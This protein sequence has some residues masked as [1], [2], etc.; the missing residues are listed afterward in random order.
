MATTRAQ[1]SV[2]PGER[3]REPRLPIDAEAVIRGRGRSARGTVVDASASGVLIELSEALPFLDHHVGIEMTMA[4]GSTVHAE[5]EIVRRALSPAGRVLVAIRLLEDAA[6]RELIRSA[7]L[8]PLRDYGR[9]QRPSR[10]KPRAP[11]PRDEVLEELRALGSRVLELALAEPDASAPPAMRRWVL[12]L[13]SE[14]GGTASPPATN[15]LLLREI[16][17]LHAR[18]TED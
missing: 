8:K 10:A 16:A 1:G 15:R 12:S 7:G 18:A 17:H 14:L 5:G 13:A 11:R 2:P 4:T 3:R 6:G 9:R